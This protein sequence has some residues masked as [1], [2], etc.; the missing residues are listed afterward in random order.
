MQNRPIGIFDSGVGG[1]T[2]LRAIERILPFEH[3]IYFGDT[4][5]VPYGNKSKATIIK[6]ST[7]NILFL[8]KKEVKIVV[9]AC[10]TASSLALDY[11]KGIFSVP[12]LGV[13]E[14]GARKAVEVSRTRRIGIIG[15][16]STIAS[17]SYEKEILRIDK[18]VCV[19]SQA[20]PLFVPFVEEGILQ[21]RLIEQLIA[22][23]LH[24]FKRKHIDTLILGCTDRKS[25]V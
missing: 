22:L 2:V 15:T 24:E 21:G 12:I 7:E 14:A 6:F 18:N 9:V 3:I 10:N 19:Y 5:R 13:I 4:A 17:K 25:V 1:L 23:Y 8:L 16:R 20:C 11:L